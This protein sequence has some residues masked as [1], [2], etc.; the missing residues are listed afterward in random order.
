MDSM[1]G[2][3]T[4]G[5]QFGILGSLQ[6]T[7]DGHEVPVDSPKQ[8]H[9][10][11]A[12]LIDVGSVVSADRL[13]EFLWAADPPDDPSGAVQT[14]VSRL[15]TRLGREGAP[16]RHVLVT[17]PPGYALVVDPSQV[18]ARLFEQQV[19]EARG[20]STARATADLLQEAL[21]LWRGRPLAEFEDARARAEAIRLEELRTAAVELRADALLAM[22][23]YAEVIGELEAAVARH[24]LRE[25]LRGQLMVALVRS[26]RQVEA[27]SAYRDLRDVLVEELGVEPSTAL[28]RLERAVL[29]QDEDLPWPAPPRQGEARTRSGGSWAW[30]ESGR[31]GLPEVP[32]SFVGRQ[33]DVQD[34]TAT[35]RQGRV[36]VLT[37]VGGVGKSRLAVRVAREV[38]D[39]YPDGARLCD[40]VGAAGSA[41]VADVVA[42]TLGVLPADGGNAEEALLAFLRGQRL[43]L[44]FDN[45]EHVV[46]GA[47]ELVD[48]VV[49]RC[50]GVD[51]LAT[52]RQSLG[53]AGER[54]WP[55][56]PL[57]VGDGLDGAAVSLF[58]DRA[59]AAEPSFA[60]GDAD[61]EAVG[62]I[63]R[64]LD[65]LP[66][67]VELA[68][69]RVRS[70]T[71]ADIV[72]RLDR[73]FELFVG[74]AHLPASRHQ[75][76]QAVIDWS[77]AQLPEATQRLFDRL[78]VFAADFGL[79]AVEQV[80]VGPGMPSREVVGRLSE[81]VDHSLVSVDRSGRHARYRL[82]ET[83]RDYGRDR[84]EEDGELGT[85]QQRH[86]EYFTSL[87]EGAVEGFQGP[88]EARWVRIVDAEFANFRTAQA[89]AQANG[90][91]DLALRLVAGL[92]TYAYH[93]LHD[94]V[95][96]W[97][98]RA[99]AQPGAEEQPG[100]AAALVTAGIGWMQRGQLQE[101][102]DHAERTL[103][104]TSDEAVR[105]RARQ[106]LAEVALQRGRLEDADRR[107]AELVDSARSAGSAYFGAL[108]HVYRAFAATYEGRLEDAMA[109]LEAGWPDAD[110]AGAPTMRAGYWHL[111][112]EV[113]LDDDPE[114]A[115]AALRSA[116][117]I[118]QSVRNRF[119]EGV[120]R[121]SAASV[122]ARHGE[123]DQALAAFRDIVDHWRTSSN[124]TY[125]WTTLHNLVVLFE[126]V[127]AALPAAVLHG[128]IETASTG[129]PAFGADAARL[130]SAATSLRRT[131]GE[132]RFA[133]A[134][135]RGRRMS[136]DEAVAH[137]LEEIDRLADRHW[138]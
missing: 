77:Y 25:H 113:R 74:P 46:E 137:A 104:A 116:I 132:E 129:A 51:V 72:D 91:V 102:H 19:E 1:S 79:E 9:L 130:E 2:V 53:V 80:C 8:R 36:V 106:L 60:L 131:L 35:L 82:L 61:R 88:D 97:A 76:L 69:A 101:A 24:P 96:D 93:R 5:L 71:P 86:A 23:R 122:E 85:W 66:L 111:E 34:V 42:T 108:G 81:L 64:R 128:A 6:V 138:T 26:G 114:A 134:R 110:A 18:D 22:G 90:P 70:M 13:A 73:R 38:A 40:L 115:L 63:C 109:W 124:W 78:A 127:G 33:A 68:A 47:A 89:W 7:V 10:L 29:Q 54:I 44:V 16:A 117:E 37:G 52:S 28:R 87:A 112:G 119:I 59:V 27:L 56:R 30:S 84:L 50:P 75:S 65:G 4:R 98:L 118:A 41:A 67:A 57:E 100:Y 49:R 126:R 105:L 48:Q 12:L 17:R 43:L 123:P 14:H 92:R 135:D 45:C 83:L 99:L 32:T 21:A 55:V 20:A 31:E 136:D 94:E 125:L 133:A 58:C 120:A 95:Y 62:E 107:A 39:A 121:V 3:G 11:A 15:R 103:A